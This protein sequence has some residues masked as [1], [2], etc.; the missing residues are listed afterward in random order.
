VFLASISLPW[1]LMGLRSKWEIAVIVGL[2][3]IWL[4]V[5]TGR[6]KLRKYRTRSW[7]TVPGTVA[8]IRVRKV[9]GGLNGVDYWK[10]TFDFTWRSAQEHTGTYAFNCTSEGMADGAVAGLQEKTVSVH[11][12][13]SDESKGILWED[14]VWDIWWDT[15]WQMSHAEAASQ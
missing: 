6:E 9:D 8:N 5:Q 11:H 10:L 15:Y 3:A 14:E 1:L 12:K 13:P 2:L 7:P 4:A